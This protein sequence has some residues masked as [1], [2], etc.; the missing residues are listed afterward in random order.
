MTMDTDMMET[1]G[2][3]MPETFPNEVEPD[4]TIEAPSREDAEVAQRPSQAAPYTPTD[5]EIQNHNLTHLPYRNWC[6]ICVKSKGKA[7]PHKLAESHQ[8][9]GVPVVSIDYAYLRDVDVD[10]V[11][12][13]PMEDVDG[14]LM[15]PETGQRLQTI[16][17]M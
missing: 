1:D 6:P 8:E 5:T 4:E 15:D 3:T 10:P 7:T 9:A 2:G 12:G 16:L 14:E 13:E 11:T 17:V